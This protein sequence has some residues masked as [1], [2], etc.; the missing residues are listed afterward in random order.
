MLENVT[1]KSVPRLRQDH[2]RAWGAERHC[3]PLQ[4]QNSLFLHSGESQAILSWSRNGHVPWHAC[5]QCY[6]GAKAAFSAHLGNFFF[7]PRRFLA[8]SP[9]LALL[10]ASLNFAIKLARPSRL[11]NPATT[12]ACLL[13]LQLL[14]L[15][16]SSIC[17]LSSQHSL[18]F[19]V[20]RILPTE[21]GLVCVPLQGHFGY[22]NKYSR[23]FFS[24]F[25]M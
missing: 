25:S 6:E 17:S 20:F 9:K 19:C 10:L 2:L 16:S 21:V 18:A 23:T 1:L 4:Q 3:S 24:V 12:A 15:S 14:Y 7:P 22:W 8:A 13:L 5:N 11:L